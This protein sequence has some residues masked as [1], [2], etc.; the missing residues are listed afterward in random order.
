[1]TSIDDDLMI[2]TAS[3]NDMKWILSMSQNEKWNPGIKDGLAFQLADPTGFFIAV[4]NGHRIGC[5]AAVRYP[6]S[7]HIGYFAVV[8]SH[9][10]KGYGMQLFEH[11]MN[12]L[13]GYNICL[14]AVSLQIENYKRFGFRYAHGTRRCV[15]TIKGKATNCKNIHQAK[16]IPFDRL[17]QYDTRH[18]PSQRKNFLISW[19]SVGTDQ[20]LVYLDDDNSIKGFAS[21]RQGVD[22][23]RV[24][25]VFAETVDIAESLLY[26]LCGQSTHTKVDFDIPQ[27]NTEG[28]RLAER[29]QLHPFAHNAR[30]YT[31]DIP[32]LPLSNIFAFT[33]AELG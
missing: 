29:L 22:A 8:K 1:M 18:V 15:G 9:R 23:N 33:C 26:A 31:G 14:D 13:N 28:L 5:V 16:D 7:A 30:M 2:M 4:L 25:P 20:S 19:I 32:D 10:G 3:T 24:G 12:H 11:A 17:L 6:N 21:I 27:S